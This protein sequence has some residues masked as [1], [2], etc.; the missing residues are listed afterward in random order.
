MLKLKV[1]FKN[2]LKYASKSIREMYLIVFQTLAFNES[3]K[4]LRLTIEFI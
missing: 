3:L 1:N 2:A 4:K